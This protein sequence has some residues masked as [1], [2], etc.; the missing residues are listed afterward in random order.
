M[1]ERTNGRFS[2]LFIQVISLIQA[3]ERRC[4]NI[5][6]STCQVSI[7]ESTHET[8]TNN[9]TVYFSS[10]CIRSLFS[11]ATS[12][13]DTTASVIIFQSIASYLQEPLVKSPTLL[14][15]STSKLNSTQ[16]TRRFPFVTRH[17]AP[18]LPHIPRSTSP[19][20]KITHRPSRSLWWRVLRLYS[21]QFSQSPLFQL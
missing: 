18:V 10:G 5:I 15:L 20:T 16:T 6:P 8:N 2:F 4:S 9:C 12:P 19:P 7:Q 1:D 14:L 17:V 13:N 11:S 21:E 3:P